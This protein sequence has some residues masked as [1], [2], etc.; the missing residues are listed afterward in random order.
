MRA[1][2]I[3]RQRLS[4][5]L[6]SIHSKRLDAVFWAVQSLLVGRRIGLTAIGRAA[7][8]QALVKHCIKRMDRLLGNWHL[9]DEVQKF[10]SA[11]AA[12]L[13]GGKKRP[14]V[15]VDWTPASRHHAALV[16]A[17]P[18]NGRALTIY[19][20]VHPLRMSHNATVQKHFL[21]RLRSVLPAG[22][23]PTIV[24]DAGFKNSWFKHVVSQN[25]D[26][27]GRIRG[28][29][30]VHPEGLKKWRSA[31]ELSPRV[32]L[33]ATDLGRWVVSKTTPMSVRL[34]AIRKSA[35]N[36]RAHG[37]NPV[38]KARS[39]AVEP[40]LLATSLSEVPAKK[41][42][43]IYATRMQIE[44]TF[45]DT[46]SHRFGW[47][48]RHVRSYHAE[49]LRILL[50][51]AALAMLVVTVLGKAVERAG[52]HKGYQANTIDGRRVL[53]LFFLG[54]NALGRRGERR[55]S[56]A[57]FDVSLRELWASIPYVTSSGERNFAGIP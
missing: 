52:L 34:V 11:L 40:W 15:L 33:R 53:S 1:A 3:L 39:R 50:L 49:R 36:N 32:I 22:C 56:A 35:K 9:H 13:I 23:R 6:A 20:E 28:V 4:K 17:V 43:S 18:V 38:R 10:F 24:S 16:A 37:S 57:E 30:Y 12:Q 7:R 41:I 55:F 48:F 45:R 27:V 21:Q 19:A 14:I 51:I 5:S 46:K 31:D 42:V 29:V 25:W 54:N 2:K 47:C 44:E 8:S 26:F